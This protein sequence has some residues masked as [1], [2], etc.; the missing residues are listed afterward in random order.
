[1]HNQNNFFIIF[2]HLFTGVYTIEALIKIIARGLAFDNNSYLRITWNWLDL[3][4][5]VSAYAK[6]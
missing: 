5:I 3:I 1:M 4:V 2:S 6:M